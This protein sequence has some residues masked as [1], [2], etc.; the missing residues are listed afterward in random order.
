MKVREKGHNGER[1]FCKFMNNV[2]ISDKSG[3]RIRFERNVDQVR[4]GG[5]DIVAGRPLA[6]EVKRQERLLIDQWWQQALSQVKDVNPIPVLAL[7]QNHKKWRFFMQASDICK[8]KYQV[9]DEDWM[10]EVGLE[11]FIYIARKLC[12][13]Y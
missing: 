3:K 11:Q 12:G 8:S 2:K 10:I 4:D 7:R 6:I 13:R 1:E 5:A 9:N